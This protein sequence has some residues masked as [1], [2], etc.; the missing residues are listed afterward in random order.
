MSNLPVI[1][2][3]IWSLSSGLGY[4]VLHWYIECLLRDV[5]F[6][7]VSTASNDS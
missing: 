6:D 3:E 1:G 2:L 4:V 5:D 7:D